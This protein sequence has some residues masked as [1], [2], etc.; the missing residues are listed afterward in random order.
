[1]NDH[2]ALLRAICENPREDTPRLVFA[3]W[4]EENGQP[5]RAAFI[6]TD[7]AMSLRDEWDADRLKWESSDLPEKAALGVRMRMWPI[8]DTRGKGLVW[9]DAWFHGGRLL[10][11]GFPWAVLVYD[12]RVL[13]DRV[14]EL[15]ASYPIDYLA[16]RATLPDLTKLVTEPWFPRISGLEWSVG[17]YSPETLRPLLELPNP[18][19]TELAP[20][21]LAI[22]PDGIRALVE[23]RLF[24]SLTHLRLVGNASQVAHAALSAFRQ[25]RGGFRLRSLTLRSEGLGN[26][27]HLLTSA[28][29]VGLPVLDI[30]NSRINS[31]AAQQF[32]TTLSPTTGLRMLAIASNPVGNAGAAALFTSPHL[33]G[34]KVLDLSYCQVGDEA[35]R[36][37]LENSPLADGLNLLNLTGSPA[38]AEMKQAVKDRMGDRVRL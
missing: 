31:A 8:P 18:P 19:L 15:F 10:R 5:E 24:S 37:L 3:D 20:H 11:R 13:R 12:L 36:E 2:D 38:S 26:S 14:T 6:R 4:L 1:M 9:H 27:V 23:S 22:S 32:A 30:S 25:L 21:S 35:L 28:L 16:F 17:R 7:I 33:A 29:P 34:L